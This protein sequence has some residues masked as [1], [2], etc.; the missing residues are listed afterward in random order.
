MKRITDPTNDEAIF[1]PATFRADKRDVTPLL[2]SEIMV[3]RYVTLQYN[4]Y[5]I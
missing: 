5:L 1:E 2:A 3:R 4:T